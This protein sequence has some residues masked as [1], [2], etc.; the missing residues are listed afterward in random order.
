M[1]GAA[2]TSVHE[3]EAGWLN[4]LV[5]MRVAMDAEVAVRWG[6]GAQK[7]VDEKNDRR[8]WYQQSQAW[9]TRNLFPPSRV[10]GRFPLVS[11]FPLPGGS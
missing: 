6:R 4:L 7:A 5:Q 1:T 10:A 3:Y 11:L 2:R 8:L 9:R